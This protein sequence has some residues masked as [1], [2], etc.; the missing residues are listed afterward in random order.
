[1]A[2]TQLMKL[3]RTYAAV[4]AVLKN[5]NEY[6]THNKL[7][8]LPTELNAATDSSNCSEC[9]LHA[10]F[11]PQGHKDNELS[12]VYYYWCLMKMDNYGWNK[13]WGNVKCRLEPCHQSLSMVSQTT[14]LIYSIMLI[15]IN[16]RSALTLTW[17]EVFGF[18]QLNGGTRLFLQLYDGLAAFANY[19]AGCIAGDQHLQEVLTLLC[20]TDT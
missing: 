10:H 12:S 2:A 8:R 7:K 6:P 20:G 3:W 5:V 9:E 15:D 18:G 16:Y 17:V 19:R 14:P 11:I 1:M 13:L 4:S